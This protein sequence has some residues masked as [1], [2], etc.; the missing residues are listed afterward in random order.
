MKG[1]PWNLKFGRSRKI[2]LL[3]YAKRVFSAEFK[4]WSLDSGWS[5]IPWKGCSSQAWKVL[6]RDEKFYELIGRPS[7]GK[8]V[9]EKTETEKRRFSLQWRVKSGVFLDNVHLLYFQVVLVSFLHDTFEYPLKMK[10][11]TKLLQLQA[12]KFIDSGNYFSSFWC[13]FLKERNNGV[14]KIYFIGSLALL[15]TT[16]WQQY[17]MLSF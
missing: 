5:S 12:A 15:T 8:I 4:V 2:F 6:V 7:S 16:C 9:L 3:K 11:M 13:F 1:F 10:P 17:K 14:N